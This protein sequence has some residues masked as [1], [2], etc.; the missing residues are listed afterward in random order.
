MGRLGFPFPWG[1][2]HEGTLERL[3]KLH[4]TLFDRKR[5]LSVPLTLLLD[6]AKNVLAIYRGAPA[7]ASLLADAKTLIGATDE[8]LHH[9]APPM[10]GLWFTRPL[11]PA[12]VAENLARSFQKDFPED[13]AAY[14]RLAATRAA[15]S[16]QEELRRELGLRYHV[17]ARSYRDQE[18]AE[19]AAFY[20]EEALRA[21]SNSPVIHHDF[22]VFLAS[23]GNL[24]EAE[25]HLRRALELDPGSDS[26]RAA[27][28]MIS[29]IR[30]GNE[31]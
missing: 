30:A 13:S 5:S 23:Y 24:D 3:Q 11:D 18:R 9:S 29:K 6:P 27:L 10:A 7:V 14:L 12:Y 21:A 20:F 1:F 15:G 22:G 2:V 16:R 25:T 26:S 28:D 8:T 17:L 4:D 31:R 19:V